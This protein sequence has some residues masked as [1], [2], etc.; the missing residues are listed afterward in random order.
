MEIS[1]YQNVILI[2]SVNLKMPQTKR[3]RKVPKVC[4]T[5]TL[6]T[7]YFVWLSW[8]YPEKGVCYLSEIYLSHN[9]RATPWNK[10]T[11]LWRWVR[12]CSM[13]R[14]H[15]KVSKEHNKPHTNTHILY[16][17]RHTHH[18]KFLTLQPSCPGSRV[19]S[20]RVVMITSRTLWAQSQ[21]RVQAK[22]TSWCN[23][24]PASDTVSRQLSSSPATPAMFQICPFQMVL[25]RRLFKNINYI[26]VGIVFG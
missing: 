8:Q 26:T 21:N 13:W 2:G 3:K 19:W 5:V 10:H 12:M 1:L 9:Y 4:V 25:T 18:K 15:I 11:S 23:H 17:H 24:K 22:E 7:S 20:A 14:H 6:T 16:T